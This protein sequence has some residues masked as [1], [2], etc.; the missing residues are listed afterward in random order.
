MCLC[1]LAHGLHT[2][3]ALSCSLTLGSFTPCYSACLRLS[4][5]QLGRAVSNMDAAAALCVE[6]LSAGDTDTAAK[7]MCQHV[8]AAM[9]GAR[10]LLSIFPAAVQAGVATKAWCVSW[11]RL[12]LEYGA[13]STVVQHV[14]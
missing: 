12:H 10:E 1:C 7:H 4:V 5:A 3:R 13:R 6:R 8:C 11:L 14:C 9:H 2:P